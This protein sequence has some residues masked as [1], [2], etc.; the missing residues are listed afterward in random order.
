MSVVESLIQSPSGLRQLRLVELLSGLEPL[1][2]HHQVDIEALEKDPGQYGFTTASL[3]SDLEVMKSWGWLDFWASFGGIGSV[4]LKQG[5]LD[6]AKEYR[7]FMK[8]KVH[9]NKAC[10]DAPALAL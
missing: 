10:R 8:N 3:E 9:R 5:A 4:I 6:T 1:D 7:T 2:D